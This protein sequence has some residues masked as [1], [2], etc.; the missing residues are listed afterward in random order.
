MACAEQPKPRRAG[1]VDPVQDL[2][3][4]GWPDGPADREDQ[5]GLY[6]GDNVHGFDVFPDNPD[7]A[8]CRRCQHS[9]G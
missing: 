5:F 1:S 7:T 4:S 6:L 8:V 9:A 3:T 2:P